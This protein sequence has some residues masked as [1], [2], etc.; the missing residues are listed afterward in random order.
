MVSSALIKAACKFAFVALFLFAFASFAPTASAS[1]TAALYP[2]SDG[3]YTQWTTS[4]GSAHFSLVDEASCNGNT[5]YVRETTV[6]ERDSY[7]INISSIPNNA[8]ISQISIT[9]CAYRDSAGG[10]NPVFGVFYRLNGANSGTGGYTLTSTTPATLGT[11]NYAGLS[12]IKTAGTTLQIGG[13]LSSGAAGARLSNISVVVTYSMKPTVALNAVSSLTQTGVTLNSTIN[14]NGFTT[15]A[16]YRYGTSNTACASLPNATST[17]NL[18]SGTSGVT[19][20]VSVA[21]LSANTTYYY[22]AVATNS[23]GTTYSTVTSFKTPA[24]TPNAITSSAYPIYSTSASIGAY[25]TPN[26]AAT[27]RTIK[28]GTSNVACSSLPNSTA[29]TSMGSG[30]SQIYGTEPLSGLT[31]STTYYYCATATNSY[32]TTYGSVFNF[33][34]LIAAPDAPTD[35]TVT[36]G[37]SSTANLLWVDNSSTETKF[38]IERSLDGST[39]WTQVGSTSANINTFTNNSLTPFQEYYYRVYAQNAGGDSGYS[40]VYGINTVVP[41]NP[42]NLSLSSVSCGGAPESMELTWQDNS[43][44]E[45]GFEIEED[46][47]SGFVLLTSVGADQTSHLFTGTACSYRIRAVNFSGN[48][49]WEIN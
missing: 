3:T 35:L 12:T 10:T 31:P 46:N 13:L 34:T 19:N 47:G 17:N 23:E 40:N 15:N 18:G 21:S 43:F 45:D 33:T 20:P 4:S 1:T 30:Y 32:G 22:C 6:G 25:I 14:P 48:S 29:P 8:T 5:D 24:Y 16:G 37:S 28:Y 44:N 11:T 39:G 41:N 26:G 36:P 2:Q 27:D 7:N 38:V 49:D 42:S 9:P